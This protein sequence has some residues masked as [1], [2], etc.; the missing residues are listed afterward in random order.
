MNT[1]YLIAAAIVVALALWLGSGW[2]DGRE[3][4]VPPAAATVATRTAGPMA[5]Q[6]RDQAAEP[7]TREIVVQGQVEPNR[8]VT[9]RAETA[10]QV[11]AIVAKKGQRVQTGEVLLRLKMNDREAR[12][13][14]AEALVRQRQQD[15]EA[16]RRLGQRGLQAETRI[17][18]ALAQLEAARAELARIR[19][20]I[21]NTTIEAPFD[22]VLND[23][24]VEFGDYVAVNDPVVTLVDDD[25]LVVSGQ[26]PQ[27]S[28]DQVGIGRVATVQLV[29]GQEAKGL[30]RYLSAM[31]D[32]ATRTFRFEV[33]VPNPDGALPGGI[34]ASIR[35]PV[36][37]VPSHLVSPALLTLNDQ[38]VLGVKTVAA[39]ATV[40]FHPVS[41]VRASADGVWVSGLAER[42][43]VIVV[44][45][46]FVQP[47][48]T[49][50]PVPVQEM[51]AAADQ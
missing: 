13:T 26:I 19:V 7:V 14:Q 22:A 31:A 28:I 41:I 12:R 33:E 3:A 36:E 48:E 16:L 27:Q 10:G 50:Q 51:A 47:G 35:I 6:V 25:P 34:S 39:D 29:T 30:I 17:N 8:V 1:S 11:T 45:H 9:L 38:G 15:Y 5:V 2:L 44:G 21:D 49:V 4:P 24:A 37:T 32:T 42:A 18:E 43:R 20:E 40:E 46:G 23:R